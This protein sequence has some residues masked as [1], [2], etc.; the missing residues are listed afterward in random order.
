MQLHRLLKDAVRHGRFDKR[1]TDAAISQAAKHK[2]ARLEQKATDTYRSEK[3]L[4]HDLL[5]LRSKT[6][7]KT[8]T[9][10][11]NFVL[12]VNNDDKK[13]IK[14]LKVQIRLLHKVFE[15]ACASHTY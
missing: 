3:K 11:E 15:H 9:Q 5:N 7:F 1:E 4:V 6:L 14:E 8:T 10:Y 13:V 12:S 2:L